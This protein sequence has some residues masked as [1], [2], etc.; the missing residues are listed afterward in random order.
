MDY[1][2]Q[3]HPNYNDNVEEEAKAASF[4]TW[5]DYFGAKSTIHQNAELPN[6][7]PWLME[8]GIGESSSGRITATRNPYFFK[9]DTEGNQLPY[10]DRYIVDIVADTQV[11]VLKAL[12]GEL[13]YQ[14]RFISDLRL[15]K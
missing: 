5:L 9:V 3:F 12:N 14:E 4:D 15:N 1:L 10:M 2:E 13:D 11:L 7:R 6:L 8:T